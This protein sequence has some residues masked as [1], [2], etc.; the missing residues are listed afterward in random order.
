MQLAPSRWRPRTPAGAAMTEHLLSPALCARLLAAA[1]GRG[2]DAA[3]VF[4]ERTLSRGLSFEEGKVKSAWQRARFGVGIRVVQGE[5]SG[6]AFCEEPDEKT[7]VATAERAALIAAGARADAAPLKE[8]V[9][10]PD[11]YR[12]AEPMTAV[13]TPERIALL[14]R[15]SERAVAADKRVS[16]VS[17][18]LNDI[19]S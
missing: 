10:R 16:W 8:L 2:G 11:R 18:F 6:Y 14:R 7:L 4:A 1:L 19:D 15:A 13:P 3:D 5:K 9:G 17:C 12:A